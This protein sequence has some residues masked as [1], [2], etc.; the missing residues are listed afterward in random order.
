[1]PGRQTVGR[2]RRRAAAIGHLHHRR[3]R[4]EPRQQVGELVVVAEVPEVKR[5]PHARV[6]KPLHEVE[7]LG[8]AGKKTTARS[9][10]RGHRP[11]RQADARP[12][13][14]RRQ[15][16]DRLHEEPKGMAA[17]MATPAAAVDHEHGS[18]EFGRGGNRFHGV[19]DALRKRAAVAA[20]EPA[21]PLQ[22]R[23]PDAGGTE[24]SGSGRRAQ[25]RHLRPPERERLKAVLRHPRDLVLQIP[26]GAGDF[27]DGNIEHRRDSSR[28]S[29]H[30]RAA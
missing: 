21:G 10:L 1:M 30:P 5:K 4:R 23:H 28:G 15:S 14:Q 9:S 22:A 25:V 3:R 24:Q 7:R 6:A 20:G 18:G 2:G 12:G 19:I 27:A 26:A 11:D 8:E 17:G 16:L 29:P 13:G